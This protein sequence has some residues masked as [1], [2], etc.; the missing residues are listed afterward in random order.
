MS[1]VISKRGFREVISMKVKWFI[2][3]RKS[4][5]AVDFHAAGMSDKIARHFFNP[6]TSILHV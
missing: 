3:E 2:A 5:H 1:E 4:L 6:L